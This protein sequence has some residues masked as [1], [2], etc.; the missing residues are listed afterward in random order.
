MILSSG[1]K[2]PIL[3][4][5]QTIQNLSDSLFAMRLLYLFSLILS[6]ALSPV[7]AQV[8]AST[9]ALEST[10]DS[11]LGP[12][13]DLDLDLDLDRTLSKR[14]GGYQRCRIKKKVARYRKKPC[15]SSPVVGKYKKGD[16]VKLTC[17]TYGDPVK[18]GEVPR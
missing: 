3:D 4:T 1:I 10:S 16:W 5:K 12:D 15:L 17:L 14:A 6:L 2:L 18:G 7:T 9:G 11:D 8:I 13:V